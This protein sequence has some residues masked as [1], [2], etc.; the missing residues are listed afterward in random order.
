LGP[1]N[2]IILGQPS[3]WKTEF[4]AFFGAGVV[5]TVTTVAP[6]S[7]LVMREQASKK[8]FLLYT[9]GSARSMQAVR[10]SAVLAH[11]IGESITLMAVAD[12]EAEK[13]RAENAIQDTIAVL[14]S[15]K[16]DV[17]GT[18][19]SV[20]KPV[21]EIVETGSLYRVISITDDGL[22]RIE[23]LYK[24]SIATEVLRNARTSVLDVR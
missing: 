14:K 9:D 19:V 10:R 5:Q 6:C 4:T 18:K 11:V 23:R 2:L 8:G 1:Y 15:M 3:R 17:A 22:S 20:G 13:A 7:V 12:S 21:E 16:I 24:A